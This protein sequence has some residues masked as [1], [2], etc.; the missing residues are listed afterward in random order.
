VWRCFAERRWNIRGRP[1][2]ALNFTRR[3]NRGVNGTAAI[4][5]P[6]E[7]NFEYGRDLVGNRGNHFEQ[8]ILHSTSSGQHYARDHNGDEFH[9]S[10]V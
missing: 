9:P 4:H 8:W 2:R 7:Q 1:K 6:R 5:C 3:C 10:C